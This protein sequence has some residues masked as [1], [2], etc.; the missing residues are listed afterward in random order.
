MVATPAQPSPNGSTAAV[1]LA[2]GGSTRFGSPKPLAPWR[3]KSF[4]EHVVDVALAS[5]AAPVIVVLGAEAKQCRSRLQGKPVT[6]VVNQRWAEG[7]STSMQAGLAA[8]PPTVSSVLFLLVDLPGVTPAVIDAL[9]ERYRLTHAP[10]IWPEFDGQ[11]GNP[12]LFDR[13]LFAELN[14]ISGDTGGKPVVLAHIDQAERVI[15]TNQG[16]VQDYDYPDQLNPPN[17]QP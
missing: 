13:S 9:I 11:R 17:P 5:Q 7:Q 3:G 15:V 1:V 14:R 12:V 10:V 8:L 2:A 16:V 4:I 6:I